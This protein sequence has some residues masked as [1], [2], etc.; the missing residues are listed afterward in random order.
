MRLRCDAGGAY[1]ESYGQLKEPSRLFWMKFG[2]LQDYYQKFYWGNCEISVMFFVRMVWMSFLLKE[3][4]VSP[5]D[6]GALQHVGQLLFITQQDGKFW[7]WVNIP[8]SMATEGFGNKILNHK[9]HVSSFKIQF[10][11]K[12]LL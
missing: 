12:K 10:I 1:C 2:K 11:I 7:E 3:K 9:R 5:V 8:G 4:S 6:E